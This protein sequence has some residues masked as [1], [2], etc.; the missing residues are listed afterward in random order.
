M[1]ALWGLDAVIAFVFVV[2]F[3]I[4]LA[5][6]SISSF[7]IGL[8]VVLLSGLAVILLGSLALRSSGYNRLATMLLLIPGVP[9]IAFALFFVAVLV[10][11]PRW[12]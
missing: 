10:F 3:F 8:W 5:D 2:F 12:N 9:G 1:R 7:N 6:G 11:N 4:G